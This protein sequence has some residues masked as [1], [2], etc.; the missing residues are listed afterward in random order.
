MTPDGQF[1]T[2]PRTPV[3][4]RIIGWAVLVAVVGTGAALAALALWVALTLI[5]VILA[6]VV[7][8][9]V[10]IRFQLWR[11]RRNLGGG[12]GIRRY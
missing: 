6:A 10:A 2:P 5:P 7:I 1:R 11:A 9:A 8:A 4:N 12:H 3:T